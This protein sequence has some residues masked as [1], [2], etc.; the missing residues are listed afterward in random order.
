[1]VAE[2]WLGLAGLAS[3]A[4]LG[5]LLTRSPRPAQGALCPGTVGRALAEQMLME[6]QEES[7]CC[8]ADCLWQAGQVWKLLPHSMGPC[9]GTGGCPGRSGELC[10]PPMAAAASLLGD[11]CSSTWERCPL[12]LLFLSSSYSS[13]VQFSWKLFIIESLNG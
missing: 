7:L 11:G 12:F 4:R 9:Q 1:M 13:E 8:E 5:L 10:E 6:P 2:I 3:A